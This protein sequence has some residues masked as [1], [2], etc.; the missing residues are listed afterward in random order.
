M[1]YRMMILWIALL[2]ILV[3][4]YQMNP[5]QDV[6]ILADSTEPNS[7]TDDTWVYL[8]GE[9]LQ[10]LL[11]NMSDVPPE[12]TGTSDATVQLPAAEKHGQT[13]S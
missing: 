2:V 6:P 1:E 11:A 7:V 5:I 3:P 12:L 13:K 8:S 10:R 9:E 4:E